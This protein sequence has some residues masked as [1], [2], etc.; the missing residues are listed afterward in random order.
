VRKGRPCCIVERKPRK[1]SPATM[2]ARLPAMRAASRP[3]RRAV[4]RLVA[5][6][7]RRTCQRSQA[8]P[9]PVETMA[10]QKSS[11]GLVSLM[12][13]SERSGSHRPEAAVTRAIWR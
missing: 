12:P 7:G 1:T 13:D 4:T 3:A 2:P 8:D 5:T 9:Q 11:G 10:C 6:T